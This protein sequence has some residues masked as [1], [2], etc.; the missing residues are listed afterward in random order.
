VGKCTADNL[1][2]MHP[3]FQIDGNF[4][5]IAGITEMLLQSHLGKPGE[6]ILQLLP[7]LPAAWH[8]GSVT[9]LR[10]RGGYTVDMTW[11][12]RRLKH[13]CIR[14]DKAG[15]I[16]L[17]GDGQLFPLTGIEGVLKLH[18]TPDMPFSI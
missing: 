7:A 12:K 14:A 18:I 4:G 3:P 5:G 10:A 15:D 11:E 6:R 13:L 2:D 16:Y 17:L 8:S 1:F 9:G